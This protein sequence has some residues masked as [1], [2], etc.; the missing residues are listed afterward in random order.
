MKR[1]FKIGLLVVF[2]IAVNVACK[3][4]N[5][6]APPPS[7]I[8]I[9]LGTTL[10]NG[11]WKVSSYSQNENDNTSNF[12]GYIFQFNPGGTVSVTKENSNYSGQWS[13]KES[14]DQLLLTLDFGSLNNLKDIS[15]DW[16]VIEQNPSRVRLTHLN[17]ESEADFLTFEKL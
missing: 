2:I 1:L 3:K 9:N 16:S 17:N 7:N 5:T 11:K 6:T 12:T 4:D 10:K 15:E 8:A 14:N 13:T